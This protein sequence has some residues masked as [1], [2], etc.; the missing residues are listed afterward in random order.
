VQTALHSLAFVAEIV[1]T[2][3]PPEFTVFSYATQLGAS[4]H[5]PSL[6]H[7]LFVPQ[8]VPVGAL[9][10]E[11]LFDEQV[12]TLQTGGAGQRLTSPGQHATPDFPNQVGGIGVLV[13]A[14]KIAVPYFGAALLR[15]QPASIQQLTGL[16]G[17]QAIPS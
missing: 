1:L 13:V 6:L 17:E 7:C 10:V 3:V 14:P 12:A 5:T 2:T 8:D 15:Q 4:T 9:A 16:E 11:Q